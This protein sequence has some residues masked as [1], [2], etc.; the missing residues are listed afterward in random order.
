MINLKSDWIKDVNYFMELP[1]TQDHAIALARSGAA[2][3]TL[4]ISEVQTRG[5]GRR[6]AGWHSPVGGLWFSFVLRPSVAPAG[7]TMLS[8][9]MGLSVLRAVKKTT[10]L[11]VC[12]KWPNDIFLEGK[13][14]GGI[15]IDMES[16]SG[17]C[18]YVVTGVG[19]NTNVNTSEFPQE[20][21]EKV[22]SFCEAAGRT[23]DNM[24]ML[25]AILKET[26]KVYGLFKAGKVS[27][28][29]EDVKKH[30]FI[31]GR[32]VRLAGTDGDNGFAEG[33]AKGISEKGG[34]L[35]ELDGGEI[36]EFFSGSLEILSEGSGAD[37]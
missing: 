30:C 14:A 3:G 25:A 19:L 11:D 15:L 24:K 32:K 28:V 29:L 5:K 22:S 26:E 31:T 34:F 7:I 17:R 13:K 9:G 18:E 4:V 36:K 1:S 6:S 27:C 20:L 8:L 10:G 33:R 21:K 35:L 2:E 12:I 16:V 37:Q 23:V